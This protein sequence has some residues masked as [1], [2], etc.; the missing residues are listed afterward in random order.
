[1]TYKRSGSVGNTTPIILDVMGAV[2]DAAFKA[3]RR[4]VVG[5]IPRLRWQGGAY[6][7][8][9]GINDSLKYLCRKEDVTFVDP[10]DEFFDRPDLFKKDGVHLNEEGKAKL[11]TGEEGLP[12][13]WTRFWQF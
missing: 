13:S 11:V 6:S 9:I 1:M 4:V 8:N 7:R 12:E 5:I 10:Y 3:Y 2:D